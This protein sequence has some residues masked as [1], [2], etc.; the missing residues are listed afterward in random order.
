MGAK[1]NTSPVA[2]DS[3]KAK[4]ELTKAKDTTEAVKEAPKPVEKAE[5]AKVE[6]K[7]NAEKQEADI[8]N[9]VAKSLE[10]MEVQKEPEAIETPKK[11]EE[12]PTDAGIEDW[13]V[14]DNA[15]TASPSPN[16]SKAASPEP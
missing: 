3:P 9:D 8:V 14:L 5:D 6:A 10:K 15:S 11:P 13:T 12:P 7:N 4:E 2:K 1:E 16:K